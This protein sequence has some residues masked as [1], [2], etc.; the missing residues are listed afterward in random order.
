[1]SSKMSWGNPAWR[2][3]TG[4][5]MRASLGYGGMW[6]ASLWT[7]AVVRG[8]RNFLIPPI[9]VVDY[10]EASTHITAVTAPAS[11]L[12]RAWAWIRLIARRMARLPAIG[13][14][15]GVRAGAAEVTFRDEDV[16]RSYRCS[17]DRGRDRVSG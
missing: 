16:P 17:A 12:A 9:H 6:H 3:V 8:R 4:W 13:A 2:A 14:G 15:T 11:C 5:D 1:M 7:S 10:S